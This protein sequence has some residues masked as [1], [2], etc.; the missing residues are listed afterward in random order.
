MRFW[1]LWHMLDELVHLGSLT[2]A[3][4]ILVH[5]VLID[6]KEGSCQNLGF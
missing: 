3:F 2:K 5:K 4:A 6:I 1:Y